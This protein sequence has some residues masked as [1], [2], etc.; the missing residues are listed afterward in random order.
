MKHY[1][2]NT[3]HLSLSIPRTPHPSQKTSSKYHHVRADF[4]AMKRTND[5][6][7]KIYSVSGNHIATLAL[8]LLEFCRVHA[9]NFEILL[10]VQG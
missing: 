8:L 9:G 5:T 2:G 4:I 7:T 10:S 3:L 6:I 1:I